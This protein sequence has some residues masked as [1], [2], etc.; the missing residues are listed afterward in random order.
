MIQ[1][2][3]HLIDF[4]LS[5]KLSPKSPEIRS[6]MKSM[7]KIEPRKKKNFVHFFKCC[8]SGISSEDSVNPVELGGD[9]VTHE[10]DLVHKSNQ[11]VRTEEYMA[12]EIILGIGHDFSVDCWCLGVMLYEFYMERHRF[13]RNV[14]RPCGA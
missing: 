6:S 2:N 10:S 14:H 5:T 7:P 3:G 1:E 4:D 9:S 13:V 8:D 11:F 12:P